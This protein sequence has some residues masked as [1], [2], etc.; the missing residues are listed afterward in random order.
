MLWKAG[1]LIARVLKES[2]ENIKSASRELVLFSE[3]E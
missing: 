2:W 3:T 1:R